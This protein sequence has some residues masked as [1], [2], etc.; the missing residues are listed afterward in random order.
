MPT[1]TS[2]SPVFLVDAYS[3]PMCLK[4]QGRA[5]Y[6]NCGPLNDFFDRVIK[7]H[8]TNIVI[9]F[10]ECTGMDS[11][12]LGLLVGVALELKH[13]NHKGSI[14]LQHV[15]GRNLELIKNLGLDRM[16]SINTEVSI[17][18]KEE[19]NFEMK[20]KTLGTEESVCPEAILKAHQ[21]LVCANS[22]NLHKFQDVISFL[23]KQINQDNQ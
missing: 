4:I 17:N 7:K 12:F 2:S 22:S 10:E 1:D 14:C 21:N 19:N 16:L 11:T 6:L 9:D 20:L 13:V 18:A 15:K 8:G 3:D 5:T 23:K